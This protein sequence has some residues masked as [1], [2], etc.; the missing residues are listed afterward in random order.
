MLPLP[1]RK[2]TA[3]GGHEPIHMC[4][5]PV[6]RPRV[7]P[8]RPAFARSEAYY[9]VVFVPRDEIEF[10]RG[11]GGARPVPVPPYAI[12]NR[13]SAPRPRK[14]FGRFRYDSLEGVSLQCLQPP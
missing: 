10:D 14:L 9:L 12:G 1:A 5:E 4:A 2:P 6:Q 8:A 3:S 7:M 13:E 11:G